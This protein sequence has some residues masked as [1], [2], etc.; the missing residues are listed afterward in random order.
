MARLRGRTLYRSVLW[1]GSLD[2]TDTVTDVVLNKELNL[3]A[4]RLQPQSCSQEAELHLANVRNTM[5]ISLDDCS[6]YVLEEDYALFE[7]NSSVF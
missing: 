7:V 1:Y 6:L 4:I 3:A 2:V 5:P